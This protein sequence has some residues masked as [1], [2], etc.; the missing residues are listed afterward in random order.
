M[1]VSVLRDCSFNSPLLLFSSS[2]EG[3][4]RWS[5][6][7]VIASTDRVLSSVTRDDRLHSEFR[8]TSE[9]TVGSFCCPAFVIDVE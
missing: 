3:S 2:L 1:Q 9:R 7:K 6:S 4:E 5:V 8:I